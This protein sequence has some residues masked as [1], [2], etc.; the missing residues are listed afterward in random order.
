MI[1]SRVRFM[2]HIYG[3]VIKRK[4]TRVYRIERSR[5]VFR[6]ILYVGFAKIVDPVLL[7]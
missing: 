5:R 3:L 4:S 1:I 6:S 7:M 2:M